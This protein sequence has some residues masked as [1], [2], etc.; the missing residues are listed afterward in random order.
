MANIYVGYFKEGKML[1]MLESY[2]ISAFFVAF[3]S[4]FYSNTWI[5]L[6]IH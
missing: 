1:D 5:N 4:L 3:Q 2:Y 6:P